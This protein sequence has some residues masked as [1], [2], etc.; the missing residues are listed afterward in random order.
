MRILITAGPTQEPIDAVRYIGNRSSGKMGAALAAA[1]RRAGHAV[2]LILG[3]VIVDFPDDLP[4]INVVTSQQ[5][6]DAVLENFVRHDLLIMAAA[7]SD[8]R[9]KSANPGK[10]PRTGTRALELEATADIVAEVGKIKRADQR[11]VGFSLE[12]Q[13]DLARTRQKLIDKHLDLIIY[14]PTETIGSDTIAATLFWADGH[15]EQLPRGSKDT[16]AGIL[17][18]RASA[19]FAPHH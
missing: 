11:T 8:F 13:P 9:P 19:L 2:T 15:S 17:L 3:P 14:N 1:A 7:V 5:M 4:R 18:D 6:L 16:I 10:L 12:A